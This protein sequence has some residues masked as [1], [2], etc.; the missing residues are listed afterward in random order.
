MTPFELVLWRG[1]KHSTTFMLKLIFKYEQIW[2]KNIH[3]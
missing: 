2:H 3:K 1:E